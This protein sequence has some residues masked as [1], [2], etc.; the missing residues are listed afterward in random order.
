VRFD[1]GPP[2][3]DELLQDAL[4]VAKAAAVQVAMGRSPGDGIPAVSEYSEQLSHPSDETYVEVWTP[5]ENNFIAL[6]DG[7]LQVNFIVQNG[8]DVDIPMVA[9][10]IHLRRTP[11]GW[12]IDGV[13]SGG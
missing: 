6:D 13:S 8:R 10:S 1:A 4:P 7:T 12:K 11:V 5:R 2:V 3:P 9:Y